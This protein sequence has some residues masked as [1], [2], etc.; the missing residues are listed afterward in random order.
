M[1]RVKFCSAW[2]AGVMAAI[3]LWAQAPSGTLQGGT[4]NAPA[5]A[6]ASTP[7]KP[8]GQSAPFTNPS[9]PFG[10]PPE[11]VLNRDILNQSPQLW[12]QQLRSQTSRSVV[13]M[14]SRAQGDKA[15]IR[16]KLPTGDAKLWVNG[17]ITKQQGQDR[18]FVTPNLQSG[19]FRYQ[20]QA[21][22]TADEV[23]VRTTRAIVFEPGADVSIDFTKKMAEPTR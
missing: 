8:G 9:L 13:P 17:Q 6:G 5:G 12:M 14:P 4:Y 20:I 2:I 21:S 18:V 11:N 16:V 19:T 3:P 10:P 23:P 22:W 15:V 1:N 7:F